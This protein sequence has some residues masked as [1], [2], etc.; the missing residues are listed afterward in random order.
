MSVSSARLTFGA[1]FGT[2]T[3][4]ANA[5]TATIDAASD[6]ANMLTSY[7]R[8]ASKDQ[9]DRQILHRLNYQDNLKHEFAQEA[10]EREKSVDEYCDKS[11]ENKT[12]Y[13][14]HYEL[15]EAAF[16]KAQGGTTTTA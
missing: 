8:E 1:L 7:V 13:N 14:R 6:G 9:R 12:R 16:A 15:I 4:A 5:A 11:P 10:A 2:I 3:S